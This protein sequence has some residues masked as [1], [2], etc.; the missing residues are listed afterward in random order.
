MKKT[1]DIL[2]ERFGDRLQ[3]ARLSVL[4]T[5]S[6]KP[7]DYGTLTV[8][9]VVIRSMTSSFILD[10]TSTVEI[11]QSHEADRDAAAVANL[12][13]RI[14]E[15][16]LPPASVE[17]TTKTTLSPE[18]NLRMSLIAKYGEPKGVFGP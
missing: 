11:Y 6:K 15:E 4:V 13:G 7:G 12:V 9:S 14:V 2:E 3:D 8:V 16:A 17:A 18:S 1:I 10:E 5:T